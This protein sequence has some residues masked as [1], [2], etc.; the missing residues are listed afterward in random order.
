MTE[1]DI[2]QVEKSLIAVLEKERRQ[3]IGS[4]ILIILST[5]FF[6]FVA[7]LV[8]MLIL[9]LVLYN[10]RYD[11]NIT[12]IGIYT[13]LNVFLATM[14]IIIFRHTF[15]P[16]SENEFDMTWLVAV[17]IFLLLLFST[18]LMKFPVRFPVAFGI[19]YTITGFF[20]LGLLGRIYL[21]LPIA[22]QNNFEEGN[23]AR[24]LLYSFILLV[25]GFIVQAY[26]EVFSNSWLWSSPD[27]DK[28]RI[29]AWFL[30]ELKKENRKSL[31]DN[32]L[33]NSILRVLFR[34]KLIQTKENMIELTKKGLELVTAERTD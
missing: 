13:L 14:I 34:L 30:I 1:P 24:N 12:A 20:I 26:G 15:S 3:A 32:K 31:Q 6:L 18:Y 19:F 25:I 23:D 2:I 33:I 7:G 11:Y 29:C 5:P 9:G 8:T 10:V 28:I 22:E 4:S 21:D 27:K 16:D 17:I